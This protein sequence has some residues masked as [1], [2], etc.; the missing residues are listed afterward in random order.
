MSQ[1]MQPNHMT[2]YV[3]DKITAAVHACGQSLSALPPASRYRVL[4]AL[5]I[6]FLDE[7]PLKES[8]DT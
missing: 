7:P 1:D 2:E 4:R 8:T 3:A 5:C 6:V